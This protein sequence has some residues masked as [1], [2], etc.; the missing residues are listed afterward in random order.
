MQ[1]VPAAFCDD[2]ACHLSRSCLQNGTL[3]QDSLWSFVFSRHYT[4]R[5]MIYVKVEL[6]PDRLHCRANDIGNIDEL[7]APANRRRY[8]Q[9]QSFQCNFIKL[10]R[11]T[12]M[13][14]KIY[15]QLHKLLSVVYLLYSRRYKQSLV[16]TWGTSLPAQLCE[17]LYDR[18]L[19]FHVSVTSLNI[20]YTGE[21]SAA[22]LDR[23]LDSGCL[24]WLVIDGG[25]WPDEDLLHKIGKSD[26]LR[27]VDLTDDWKDKNSIR[28]LCV[29][30]WNSK[31]FTHFNAS[32]SNVVFGVDHVTQIFG[33]FIEVEKEDFIQR[34]SIDVNVS[35]R[36]AIKSRIEELADVAN[37]MLTKGKIDI[38][39]EGSKLLIDYRT[40]ISFNDK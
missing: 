8:M 40:F 18:F 2:V 7:L 26:S 29:D 9:V 33:R 6:R 27:D 25:S 12:V 16:F 30:L 13:D 5:R 35:K 3:A 24:K 1:S 38:K 20:R 4:N 21:N 23:M 39:W 22:Y 11:E 10:N 31:E 34:K 32:K 28:Q 17:S 14:P 15:S 36:R 19:K 37:E